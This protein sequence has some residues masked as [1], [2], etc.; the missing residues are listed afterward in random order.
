ML[1]Q[2]RSEMEVATLDTERPA[3]KCLY[4]PGS[5][6][7]HK[8]YDGGYDISHPASFLLMNNTPMTQ[9][10]VRSATITI[11]FQG[12]H[13]I[14]NLAIPMTGSKITFTTG[15]TMYS[16]ICGC[17]IADTD[18]DGDKVFD[19]VDDCPNGPNKIRVGICRLWYC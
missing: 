17:G 16:G 14:Q 12:D 15:L 7:E 10:K 6:R 9:E 18:S 11:C 13:S 19:C 8:D 4:I 1:I 5:G 3:G 2:I